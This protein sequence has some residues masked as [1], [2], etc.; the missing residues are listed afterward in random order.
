M[1]RNSYLLVELLFELCCK[2]DAEGQL[3]FAALGALVQNGEVYFKA[4]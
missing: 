3:R 4:G 1:N 2:N